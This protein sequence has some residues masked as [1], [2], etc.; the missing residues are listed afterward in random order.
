MDLKRIL[1]TWGMVIGYVILNAYGAL[2]LKYK[3]NQIGE[4]PF[5]SVQN[6]FRY[7]FTLFKSPLVITAVIAIFAS[8]FVWMAALSRMEITVAYPSAVGLNFFII[9]LLGIFLFDESFS[10]YKLMGIIFVF[11]SILFLAK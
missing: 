8:A 5:T 1:L 11:L 2:M 9:I 3:I 4:I 7:F 6:T 10:I